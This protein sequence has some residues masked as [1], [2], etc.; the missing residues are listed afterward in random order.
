VALAIAALALAFPGQFVRAQGGI[1]G[2]AKERL[3]APTSALSKL[4][5]DEPPLTTN[6][7]DA[8]DGVPSLDRFNPVTFS[9][10]AEMPRGSDGAFLIAPGTYEFVSQ[11]YCLK[12]GTYGPAAGDGYLHAGLKGPEAGVIQSILLRSA[13]HPEVKQSDVQL[14]LWAII[15]RAK[16][17]ETPQDVRRTA[18][19]LLTPSELAKLDGYG[20]KVV[21]DAVRKQALQNVPAP[22]RRILETENEMRR[23]FGAT[24]TTFADVERLAVLSGE[25]PPDEFTGTVPARRWSYREGGYFIRYTPRG[26]QNTLIQLYYPQTVEIRRDAKGRIISVSTPDGGLDASYEDAGPMR[27]ATSVGAA[28]VERLRAARLTRPVSASTRSASVGWRLPPH[29]T[30]PPPLWP[31]VVLNRTGVGIDV[32]RLARADYEDLTAFRRTIERR[33][34]HT[35]DAT[36]TEIDALLGRAAHA[37]LARWYGLARLSP[38]A[39]ARALDSEVAPS[40]AVTGYVYRIAPNPGASELVSNPPLKQWPGD[41]AAVPPGPR[42]RLG[43]STRDGSSNSVDQASSFTD[44]LSNASNLLGLLTD[45]ASL[46]GGLIPS[47]I[48]GE[49][50]N[51]AFSTSQAISSSLGGSGGSTDDGAAFDVSQ[52]RPALR[53][54]GFAANSATAL[55]PA[56][57]T[58]GWSGVVT[59]VPVLSRRQQAGAPEYT[60]FFTPRVVA[61][62]RVVA[63]NRVSEAHATAVNA[64]LETTL[65]MSARLDA[66]VVARRRLAAAVKAHNAEWE[67]LQGQALLHLK[68]GAGTD[69]VELADRLAALRALVETPSRALVTEDEMRAT[70]RDLQANGLPPNVVAVAHVMGRTDEDLRQHQSQY[71]AVN[72]GIGAANYLPTL[73]A[74][75]HELRSYG[76]YWA[77]LPAIAAPWQ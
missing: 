53:S 74:L 68:H 66:A 52:S 27:F 44:A 45:P 22:L 12:P 61:F 48:F 35:R 39:R 70:Q 13:D 71:L 29:F 31:T 2:K 41:G 57:M 36:A 3:S 59:R 11:S 21:P 28:A 76:T 73:R 8:K 34:E 55:R 60:S 49:G 62:P 16:L 69:M 63:T 33:T 5:G 46:L 50:L 7:E 72:P 67:N 42:Q 6:F 19:Q 65:R 9:P 4:F 58:S 54:T 47:M 37:A 24:Q 56:S 1:F 23:A 26:Y 43:Q 18:A 30:L 25:A 32:V 38:S 75:E 20:L 40:R 10:M 64:V 77:S 17:T 14:L 51:W 15:A